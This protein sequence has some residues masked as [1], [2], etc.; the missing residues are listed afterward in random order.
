MGCHDSDLEQAQT[1]EIKKK[2]KNNLIVWDYT[3]IHTTSFFF[4]FQDAYDYLQG[5]K[6]RSD[7]QV[8]C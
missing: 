5:I 4:Q 1:T 6:C 7:N 3:C 8:L 2:E